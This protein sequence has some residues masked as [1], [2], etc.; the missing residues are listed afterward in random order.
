MQRRRVPRPVSSALDGSGFPRFAQYPFSEHGRFRLGRLV[1]G[2]D[3][4]IAAFLLYRL[5]ER[6]DQPARLDIVLY[7]AP[8]GDS[9]SKT[10]NGGSQCEI[11]GV[12]GQFTGWFEVWRTDFAQPD[13]SVVRSGIGV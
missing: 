5:R 12:K 6:G 9:N 2:I 13:S 11:R 4:V 10:S 1:F 7:D 3:Q 8:V